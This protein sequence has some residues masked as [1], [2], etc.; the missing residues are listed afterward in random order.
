MRNWR[1]AS[2]AL[3]TLCI[4]T[5]LGGCARGVAQYQLYVQA[6][7]AQYE[8]GDAILNAVAR[9]ERIVVLRSLRRGSTIRRFDPDK[10][11]YFVESVDP[12]LTGAIRASL[13]SLKAYNEAL[14]ALANGE[15]AEALTNRIGTL[16]SNLIG[17]GAAFGAIGV[18]PGVAGPEVGALAQQATQALN[19]ATPIIKQVA[20]FATREAF[21]RQL[22]A[23]YPAMHD[24]LLALRNGT[25]AM[26]F[27]LE[28][29]RAE[30]AETPTGLTAAGLASLE[31]DRVQLAGWVVLMD[32]AL[33]AMQTAVEA[34]LSDAPD[35]ELADLTEVSVELRVLAEKIKSLRSKP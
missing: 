3:L 4:A 23:T 16:A 24:L 18:V 19:I 10:A 34:A 35:A 30:R 8:Q 5:V 11:A 29:S 31:Q 15:A 27:V 13:K 33:V 14:G 22:I 2:G 32:K 7:N 21:R 1:W 9:A 26:F 25:P 12:P 6:F 20:T 17:A 28:R